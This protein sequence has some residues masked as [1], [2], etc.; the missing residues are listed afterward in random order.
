MFDFNRFFLYSLN[1]L[2]LPLS[3]EGNAQFKLLIFNDAYFMS[4][5]GHVIR[6]SYWLGEWSDAIYKKDYFASAEHS[7]SPQHTWPGKFSR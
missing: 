5:T 7:Y 3:K 1:E 6:A 4:P 2:E